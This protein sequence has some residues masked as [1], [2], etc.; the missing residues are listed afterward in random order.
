MAL[1]SAKSNAERN[2][3]NNFLVD[4]SL[5]YRALLVHVGLF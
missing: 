1:L 5:F 2:I 3:A 4:A